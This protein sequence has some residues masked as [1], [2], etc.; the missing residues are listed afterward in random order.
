[1]SVAIWADLADDLKDCISYY[2][3][4]SYSLR[5]TIS[6]NV[7]GMVLTLGS[8]KVKII[9]VNVMVVVFPTIILMYN[10]D[11]EN[12]KLV[13]EDEIIDAILVGN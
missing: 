9:E 8:Y 7:Y 2:I 3:Y 6:G 5:D 11:T 4:S 12:I 10:P 13:V 1:M